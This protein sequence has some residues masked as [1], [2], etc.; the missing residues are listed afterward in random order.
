MNP[1][2]SSKRLRTW[3]ALAAISL[4][5]ACGGYYQVTD[6]AS[7]KSYYTRDIDRDEGHARF[8][9][10]ASGDKVNLSG[11]EVRRITEEQYE[12]AVRK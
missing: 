2:M 3:S 10:K 5:A 1:L 9:D 6:T 12:N 7:G 11:F 4:L 8:V